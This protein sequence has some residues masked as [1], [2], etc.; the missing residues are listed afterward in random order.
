M[1]VS[2]AVFPVW[3]EA[4]YMVD[5][6]IW[7]GSITAQTVP[8]L[9]AKVCLLEDSFPVGNANGPRLYGT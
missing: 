5:V 4:M 8:G 1:E 6:V 9:E 3:P 7:V 2:P